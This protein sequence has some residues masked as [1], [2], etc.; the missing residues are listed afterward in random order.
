MVTLSAMRKAIL[1]GIIFL[2][3]LP[4]L[5]AKS[6]PPEAQKVLAEA[7]AQAAAAHKNVFLIF[8][9]SWC[10]WCKVLDG[11]LAAPEISPI[12]EK[13]FVTAHLD[14]DERPDKAQLVNPGAEALLA[15]FG[16]AKGGVPVLIILSPEG[17]VTTDSFRPVAG[18]P[19][20]ENI[21][22]PTEPEE[23]DWFMAMLRKSAPALTPQEART[24]EAR[25]RNKAKH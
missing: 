10:G 8:H 16:G 9:A 19:R 1:L 12:F 2:S 15:R 18:K 6:A 25:L 14:V 24:V 13:Y 23:V 4:V 20:G 3:V 7:Q 17:T 11:F 22:Y 21:G 5:V